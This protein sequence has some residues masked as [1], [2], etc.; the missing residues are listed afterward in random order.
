MQNVATDVRDEDTLMS[1]AGRLAR[2]EKKLNDDEHS[3]LKNVAGGKSI[4][5]ITRDLLEA[6]NPDQQIEQ[7][8]K[9]FQ[10]AINFTPDCVNGVCAPLSEYERI[11]Y[12]MYRKAIDVGTEE[13][14]LQGSHRPLTEEELLIANKNKIN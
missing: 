10:N 4:Q 8:V 9:Q 6:V 11:V 13:L 5:Q 12:S 14:L 1:L 7:A 2:L 3:E